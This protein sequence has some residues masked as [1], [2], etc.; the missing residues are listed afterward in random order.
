M[1]K[2]ELIN[3]DYIGKIEI[4]RHAC[5][6]III[7]DNNILL[8]YEKKSDQYIIP[9]GGLEN[10]ESNEECVI[11]E[12]KEETGIVCEVKKYYLEIEELFSNM[13][14]INHYFIVNIK[15][16]TND[17]SLTDLEK[18]EDLITKWI[19]INE[20]ISIF[21]EYELFKDI[22][23]P[24]YGLYRRELIALKEYINNK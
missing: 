23:I 19:D 8:G 6:G 9:G 17:L 5:R 13:K 10:N 22:N 18:E 2:I 16:E 11:R 21:S 12:V 3:L 14:H 20:A 7:K 1:K 15:E 4:V 24:K